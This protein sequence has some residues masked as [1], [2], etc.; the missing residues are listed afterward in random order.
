MGLNSGL[1][2]Y[3]WFTVEKERLSSSNRKPRVFDKKIR[4]LE[5]LEALV[6]M[7]RIKN[8]SKST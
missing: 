1:L 5:G 4:P 8:S 2:S 3:F 7:F 6:V